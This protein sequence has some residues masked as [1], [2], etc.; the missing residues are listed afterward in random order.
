MIASRSA[1]RRR[2]AEPGLINCRDNLF[3][4][5]ILPAGLLREFVC[6]FGVPAYKNL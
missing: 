5:Q 3:T 1:R 6:S 4:N 2:Y